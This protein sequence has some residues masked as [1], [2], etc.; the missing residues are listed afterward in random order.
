VGV[1]H[2]HIRE[3][4]RHSFSNQLSAGD[5][6]RDGV[7][8]ERRRQGGLDFE[9]SGRG[10]PTVL[11]ASSGGLVQ[12][13]RRRRRL[14]DQQLACRAS[15]VSV[16]DR[17]ASIWPGERRPALDSF[18]SPWQGRR[19]RAPERRLRAALALLPTHPEAPRALPV[20]GDRRFCRVCRPSCAGRR[21]G[22]A[23]EKDAESGT[24]HARG[25]EAGGRLRTVGGVDE[26]ALPGAAR[27][28]VTRRTSVHDGVQNPVPGRLSSRKR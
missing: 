13:P 6:R 21:L 18:E 5:R 12:R 2:G 27:R 20:G 28:L 3:L 1:V 15:R 25:Q 19:A 24:A 17:L 22:A 23:Q 10:D 8:S 4:L 26:L 16:R 9:R 11:E 7:E 14:P